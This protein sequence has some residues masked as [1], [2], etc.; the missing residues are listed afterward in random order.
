M[1]K[2]IYLCI[3]ALFASCSDDYV[4]IL[5]KGKTIPESTDDLA[6]LLNYTNDINSLDVNSSVQADD[7]TIPEFMLPFSAN[8]TIKAYTWQDYLYTDAEQDADWVACYL[9]ISRANFVLQNL[10]TYTPGNEFDVDYTKGRALFVRANY[11]FY[12]VN[13]Y[14]KHYNAATAETDLAVP[15]LLEMDIN[16]SQARSTVQEVYSQ[17]IEDLETAI[18]LLKDSAPHRTWASKAAAYGLLGR[19]YLYQEK[20]VLAQ[21][22]SKKALDLYSTLTDYNTFSYVSGTNSSKGVIGYESNALSNEENLFVVES[23]NYRT[24]LFYSEGLINTFDKAKDLRFWYFA[25]DYDQTDA[26]LDGYFMATTGGQEPFSGINV[27]EVY[28]N[29]CEALMKQSSDDRTQALTY[30]N[31]LRKN[32][33]DSATYADFAST[34]DSTVLAEIMLERRRELR[35]SSNRWFDMKRLGLTASRTVDG[36]TF[37]I[38]GSSNNYVWAIPLNVMALNELL[39]QNERGL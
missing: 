32:R 15:L 27:P 6:M 10:D 28:L 24:E 4:D 9:S 36:E 13:G 21:E 22:Y 38:T 2:I 5:P 7:V 1:K 30:L 26:Y 17:V 19:V 3:I 25:S 8:A 31:M 37:T 34:D 33:Y 16:A 39:V 14:G 11:Y 20:Y 18:P 29:Y 35:F 12:L 23:G